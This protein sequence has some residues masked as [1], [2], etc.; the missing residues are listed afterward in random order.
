MIHNFFGHKYPYT[1]FHE[2]N[3]DW[4]LEEFIT[5]KDELTALKERVDEC[6]GDIEQIKD[7]IIA[8]NEHIE[9]IDSSLDEQLELIREC[10]G[11]IS[12]I[13]ND[14]DTRIDPE[15]VRLDGRIDSLTLSTEYDEDTEELTFSLSEEEVE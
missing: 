9:R 3:L 6:E 8:I 12:D 2:L 5:L 13:V 11:D 15:L 1:D 14:I 4:F 10:Q 7:E